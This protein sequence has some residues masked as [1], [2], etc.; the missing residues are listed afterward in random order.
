MIKKIAMLNDFGVIDYMFTDKRGICLKET[1]M[2]DDQDL[3]IIPCVYN[4]N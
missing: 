4:A 3:K 1:Y 2:R